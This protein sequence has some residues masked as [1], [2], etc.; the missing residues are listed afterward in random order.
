[1]AG[2]GVTNQGCFCNVLCCIFA[3]LSKKC[4]KIAVILHRHEK[5]FTIIDTALD[6]LKKECKKKK[7][8]PIG[9]NHC[10]KNNNF[11]CRVKELSPLSLMLKLDEPLPPRKMF[12]THTPPSAYYQKVSLTYKRISSKFYSKIHSERMNYVCL[13]Y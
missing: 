10:A 4:T 6:E 3:F 7:K 12:S 1:M 5:F 13:Q 8:F 11:L 2:F 9:N